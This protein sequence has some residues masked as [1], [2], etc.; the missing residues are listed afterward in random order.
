[1]GAT[2]AVPVIALYAPLNALL[3]IYLANNVSNA[4][5][6]HHVAIGDGDSIEVQQA[7][8]IHGN[9]AEFVPL[10]LLMFLIVELMGGNSVALHVMGGSLLVARMLH[11]IGMVM[12]KTPNAPRFLGTAVTWTLIVAASGYALYLR[13]APHA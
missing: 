4:R 7:S 8:R 2:M 12:K 13:F 6:K 11:P 10:A 1:M 9:N 5:R 3:N